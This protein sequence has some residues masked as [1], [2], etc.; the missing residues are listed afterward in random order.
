MD[1]RAHQHAQANLC[2]QRNNSSNNNNNNDNDRH[3]T[4][5]QQYGTQ[6][7]IVP[8]PN[9]TTTT[10]LAG[11]KG[12]NDG[13]TKQGAPKQKEVVIFP[14]LSKSTPRSSNICPL[15]N[16]PSSCGGKQPSLIP[17]SLMFPG[18]FCRK[19]PLCPV[20]DVRRWV[21]LSWN[22]RLASIFKKRST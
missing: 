2:K 13:Y 8:T 7:T 1:D 6:A 16:K 21:A 18:I 19:R 9:P 11:G 17:S 4:A 15:M 5:A 3:H 14:R 22:S 10:Q 20:L 12:S